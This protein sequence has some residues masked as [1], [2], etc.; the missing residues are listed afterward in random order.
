[1]FPLLTIS[2]VGSHRLIASNWSDQN[3][4]TRFSIVRLYQPFSALS[5]LPQLLQL[6]LAHSTTATP[7]TQLTPQPRHF[8]SDRNAKR[9]S[10]SRRR[11]PYRQRRQSLSTHQHS[12]VVETSIFTLIGRVIFGFLSTWHRRCRTFVV[13]QA[14]S[15]LRI[16]T[17]CYA[18]SHRAGK[19]NQYLQYPVIN[20]L[21]RR[22]S[23][24]VKRHICPVRDGP[25]RLSANSPIP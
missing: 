16:R 11:P 1:M 4:A 14:S 19:S 17:G 8:A 6:P 22:S 18:S 9:L 20:T 3:H 24:E 21:N 13:E 2:S 15:G 25:F 12:G 7:L 5:P 23:T 10:S